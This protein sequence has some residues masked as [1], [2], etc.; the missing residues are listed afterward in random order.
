[1]TL[2]RSF[3]SRCVDWTK[4]RRDPCCRKADPR[5]RALPLRAAALVGPLARLASAGHPI[6]ARMSPSVMPRH[7]RHLG[8]ARTTA[9]SCTER[10]QRRKSAGCGS[11]ISR[12][13]RVWHEPDPHSYPAADRVGAGTGGGEAA[14]TAAATVSAGRAGRRCFGRAELG[15]PA[16]VVHSAP[17]KMCAA[18]QHAGAAVLRGWAHQV[19]VLLRRPSRPK[20]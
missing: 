8:G 19:I 12:A 11:G 13:P 1:M 4:A 15:A 3:R 7:A 9:R 17:P 20:P 2:T 5:C 16:R 14:A 18:L 10:S 6:T